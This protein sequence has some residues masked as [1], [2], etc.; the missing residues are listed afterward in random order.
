MRLLSFAL[1][2]ASL[3]ALSAAY[4]G[5]DS[6]AT[7]DVE[8]REAAGWWQRS[9]NAA[10]SVWESTRGLFDRGEP[11]HFGEVWDDVLPPLGE[12]LDLQERQDRLPASSWLGPDRVSNRQEIDELLDEA[13]EIL[14]VSP[15]RGYRERIA[16]LRSEIDAAKRDIAEYRQKRISAPQD[17]LVKRSVD[18]YDRA[19]ERRQADIERYTSELSD[20][21]REFAAELRSIGLEVSDE[22][23]EFLLST[24]VGDNLV[25]LG[26][27][28][29]N[30]KAITLQLDQLV[31]ASGEDLESA[32]RYYGM[33]VILLKALN[34]MHL[35]IEQL[36]RE[37]YLPQIDAIIERAKALSAETRELQRRSPD[38]RDLL[39]LNL[40]AQQLTIQAAGAYR[41]YLEDQAR[42]VH[43]AR[44]DLQRDIDAAWN[45]YE[46]VRVS[47]ELVGLVRSSRFLLD[48][49]LERQVPPLRPFHN[50]EMNREFEKLTDQL[51]RGEP[52]SP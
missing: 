31:E 25:D 29:D 28:F 38:K 24:V 17:S 45:T 40:E 15:V 20:V 46:T 16:G 35:Q 49:L 44:L 32:R 11:N 36:I 13:V 12:A 3:L 2:A 48:G 8:V 27:V 9:R 19:I 23:L 42:Q 51:R 30:V 43:F 47:G 50:L 26:V 37:R 5:T 4:A 39:A 34:R 22:Q 1:V 21:R 18:D 33:Y 10:D 41:G 7:S 52:R 14:S 6:A